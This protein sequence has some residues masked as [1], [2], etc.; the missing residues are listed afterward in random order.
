MKSIY[1]KELN[2]HREVVAQLT[3]LAEKVIAVSER[4]SYAMDQ[5]GKLL[6]CGNGGSAADAQ[7]FIFSKLLCTL[8]LRNGSYD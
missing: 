6:I 4:I 7:H 2:E 3:G 8:M 1:L 5:G